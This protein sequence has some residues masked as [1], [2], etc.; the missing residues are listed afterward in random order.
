MS[1]AWPPFPTAQ[2]MQPMWTSPGYLRGMGFSQA[3][4]LAAQV[5]GPEGP[6][7]FGMNCGHGQYRCGRLYR[8]PRPGARLD[9]IVA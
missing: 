7:V 4:R 9:G 1:L 2:I 8:L 5:Y 3:T 6:L